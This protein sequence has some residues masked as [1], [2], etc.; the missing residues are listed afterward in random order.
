[1]SK[2]PHDQQASTTPSDKGGEQHDRSIERSSEGNTIERHSVTR[3][4][5]TPE[6]R[7]ALISDGAYRKAEQRGFAP[8]SEMDDWLSAEREVDADEAPGTRK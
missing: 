1:M 8:G 6:E 4:A 3:R 2:A 7:Y 5:L